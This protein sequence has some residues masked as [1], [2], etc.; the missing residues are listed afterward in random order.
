[1]TTHN[2]LLVAFFSRS[3]NTA[4]VAQD[5]AT[6]LGADIEPIHD[7]QHRVGWL[8]Y[9]RAA[10]HAWQQNPAVIDPP[11]CSPADYSLTLV[12]TPV[13]A[14]QMTPAI[15]AYLQQTRGK[16]HRLAFFI[17]AGDTDIA[18]LTPSLEALVGSKAVASVGF[19]ARELGSAALYEKKLSAFVAAIK[20][21]IDAG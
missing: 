3:G 4:R 16:H 14:W 10:M 15:R 12:G 2:K 1:M 11:R 20:S 8:G 21:V 18:K 5:L 6:R 19:N 9:L 7:T 13:W 17:T